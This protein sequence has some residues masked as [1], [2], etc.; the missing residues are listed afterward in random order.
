M[1]SLAIF[2]SGGHGKVVAD[3]ALALSWST[4]H[5]YDDAYINNAGA[6]LTNNGNFAQLLSTHSNYDAVII[7][8][9]DSKVRWDRQNKLQKAGAKIATLIHPF[10][11]IS[12]HAILGAGTV[13]M[14]GVIINSS[15]IVGDA[16]IINTGS[17][18]DH[19]CKIGDGSHICPGVHLAG[20][21][22]VGRFTFIGIGTSISP[23]V[24]IG[25]NVIIGAGSVVID[26]VPDDVKVVGNPARK[27][28]NN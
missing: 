26:H 5:F 19:D 24:H 18:I 28:S 16:C 17:T 14:P 21:I 27:I 2:G 10:S 4:I 13:V 8:I 20:S 25:S 22:I 3:I 7:A 9:G 1:S 23:Q 15:A 11:S 12:Q 6:M